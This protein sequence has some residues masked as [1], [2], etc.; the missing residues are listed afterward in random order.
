MA[1]AATVGQDSRLSEVSQPRWKN[2]HESSLV[3]TTEEWPANLQTLAGALSLPGENTRLVETIFE[4][5]TT[6]T[7][8]IVIF[9][10]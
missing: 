4:C 10:L 7:E 3:A 1:S 5:L 6:E 2:S 8:K 9:R